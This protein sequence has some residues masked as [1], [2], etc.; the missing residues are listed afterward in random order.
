[1]TAP[2]TLLTAWNIRAKKQLGQNFLNDPNVARAIVGK[3]GL[4]SDDVVLEIGPGLGA[5]TIPAA[6]AARR[7][8][9]VDKDGRIIGLLKTELLAAG[10]D[11]V[12]IREA[13][14][15]RVDLPS[16]SQAVGRPLVV[17]GNLPYNI[18]SQVIVQ[19]V[20]ARERIDRAVLMLQREMAQRICAAPGSKAYGRLSVMLGY[21]AD[22]RELM[23]VGA[24]QFFPAPKVDSTVVGI[25]FA[26]PPSVPADDEQLLFRVVRAAFGKRRKTLRNALSQSDLN[27]APA[28][29]ER[30]LHQARIDPMRRAESLSVSEFV[31][32]SNVI[33]AFGQS[34]V[35]VA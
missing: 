2:R 17:M 31:S 21:C 3:I 27:L 33:G 12:E 35:T 10:I 15:L 23:Q 13:D 1:M 26:N 18:S 25:Q 34:T 4:C 22:T 28:T 19:L 7:L 9:A 6:K 20:H 14:I 8:I 11:N 5:I 24:A 16:I 32:L 30:L 29:C